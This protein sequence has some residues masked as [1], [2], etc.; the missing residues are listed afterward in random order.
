MQANQDSPGRQRVTFPWKT[1]IVVL[2][3]SLAVISWLAWTGQVTSAQMERAYAR[4]A[5]GERM[6]GKIGRLD[7]VLTGSA[8]LAAATSDP[9]WKARY[10]KSAPQLDAAIVGAMKLASPALRTQFKE[11]TGA[12][13]DQ[14]VALE[15]QAFKAVES[16][17]ASGAQS[18][19]KGEAYSAAKRTYAEGEDAFGKG[20]VAETNKAVADASAKQREALLITLA[21][22]AVLVVGWSVLIRTLLRWRRDLDTAARAQERQEAER[23]RIETD[24]AEQ[25]RIAGEERLK[26]AE[27][28][29]Q[30]QIQIAE[31]QQAV[32]ASLANGLS[33]LSSG[34]LTFR[35][36]DAF[37]AEYEQLRSDFNDA[38][39]ALQ[40]TMQGIVRSVHGIGSGAGEISSATNDLARRTEQQAASLEQTAAAIDELTSTVR[41]SADG[42]ERARQAVQATQGNADRGG[43]V[44]VEAIA[45][46]NEIERSAGEISQIIGVIDE[47]AFQ[48]NLLALNA[49]V[50]AARAGDA[51]KGFA[52]VASEVRALAQRSAEAAKEIKALISASG[53]HV[54]QGVTLVGQTGE[55]LKQIVAQISDISSVVTS[56]ASSAK[57][58]ATGL[59]EINVAVNQMDQFTQQNAAMVEQGN[60]ASDGLAK[61]ARDLSVMVGRFQ[62][63]EHLAVRAA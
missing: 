63:D 55:A 10:D 17:D 1:I 29:R 45:A 5:A 41:N 32:V 38:V 8:R 15:S 33:K 42:A 9:A 39:T 22:L 50:E 43:A 44:V 21:G 46:M 53:E 24:M 30:E 35:L 26:A 34:D 11:Q 61:E 12:A 6:L 4:S 18:I 36:R 57:E 56:I 19:L 40:D 52:V 47:I 49:G 37:S 25:Q 13:N 3:V 7:E 2:A 62:V 51:G 31:R 54:G 16:A 14:L 23:R 60:A 20:L 27:A 28:R 58:Q 48:T 59:G